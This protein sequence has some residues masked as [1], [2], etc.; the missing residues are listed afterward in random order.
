MCKNEKNVKFITWS[1]WRACFRL[2]MWIL[3]LLS[4]NI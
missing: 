2:E 1:I 3:M 4:I